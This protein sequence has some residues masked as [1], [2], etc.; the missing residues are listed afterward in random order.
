MSANWRALIA[1]RPLLAALGAMAGAAVIGGAAYEGVQLWDRHTGLYG[2]LLAS[3][4]RR[5][6]AVLIGKAALSDMPKFHAAEAA[7]ELRRALDS[8]SLAALL[9]ADAV[10]GRMVEAQGWVLPETLARICA[11]AAATA[12]Y[13]SPRGTL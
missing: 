8:S 2:D 12:E 1:R 5:H 3:L 10:A 4:G 9:T 6:Q 13:E 7:R 11:V